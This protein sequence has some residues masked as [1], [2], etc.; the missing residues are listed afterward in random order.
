MVA[1]TGR[2]LASTTRAG[3]A[4]TRYSGSKF[5]LILNRCGEE[6]LPAAAERLL[7][8]M[9]ES[10]VETSAGP[11]WALLSIGAVVLPLHAQAPGT[12]I[13][14]AEDALA[15]TRKQT[16]DGF[17]IYRHAP[18]RSLERSN[19]VRCAGALMRCLQDQRLH[20]TFQPVID[21]RTR[22][23]VFHEALLR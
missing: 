2:R 17:T 18:E 5:G 10:V 1:E 9:R 7:A 6:E 22:E 14:C 21:A 12:A 19:N 8:I 23:P 3:D 11:V 16:F 20:I 4:I 15:E 13:A